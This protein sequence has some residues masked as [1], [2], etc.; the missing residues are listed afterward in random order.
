VLKKAHIYPLDF[1]FGADPERPGASLL[2]KHVF[3][4]GTDEKPKSTYTF[5]QSHVCNFKPVQRLALVS[6]T[7]QHLGNLDR[8]RLEIVTFADYTNVS[9]ESGLNEPWSMLFEMCG[10]AGCNG[11]LV[12]G[13]SK[14]FCATDPTHDVHQRHIVRP[15][16]LFE[17]EGLRL[18]LH[19]G[20][21]AVN[22][23]LAHGF[24]LALEKIGGVLVRSIGELMDEETAYIYDT[25]PGG[26]GV[27]RLLTEPSGK[28]YP[29]F[30]E[31]L[32]TISTVVNQCQCDDG[33]PHCLFQYGCCYW[34]SPRTLSRH[35]LI[36]LLGEGL[37]LVPVDEDSSPKVSSSA[38]Q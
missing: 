29:H 11:V 9:Y 35:S 33:C 14:T 26:S 38:A 6:R 31:A 7:G 19:N 18:H 28:N 4:F 22:H 24:R 36:T 17:T 20:G 8:G 23:S 21:L 16:H 5:T 2:A 34:N 32:E 15:A 10:V 13:Q 27:T 3:R 1:R 30:T 37:R 12:H 25:T